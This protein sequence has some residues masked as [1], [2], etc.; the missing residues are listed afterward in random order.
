MNL[1]RNLNCE[2]TANLFRDELV[3]ALDEACKHQGVFACEVRKAAP[4][5][6][7]LALLKTDPSL[8]TMLM[9]EI[10]AVIDA[11]A[12]SVGSSRVPAVKALRRLVPELSIKDALHIVFEA[13]PP[14]SIDGAR[15]AA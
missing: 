12:E 9:T 10:R 13:A 5:A 11:Y 3:V 14:G 2:A 1:Y 4:S 7:F 15:K 6:A 8:K